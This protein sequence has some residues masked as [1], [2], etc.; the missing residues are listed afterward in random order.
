MLPHTEV[1]EI[2]GDARLEEVVVENTRT[3]ERRALRTP[4]LFNFIGAVPRTGWL[5]AQIETD[6]RGF[7]RPRLRMVTIESEDRCSA[8]K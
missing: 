4:A 3:K 6:P 8:C 2:L 7:I 5:P 1:R